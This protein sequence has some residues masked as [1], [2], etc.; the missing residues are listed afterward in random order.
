MIDR[1]GLAV[2]LGDWSARHRRTAVL[3]WLLFVVLATA[4]GSMA[5]SVRTDDVDNGVGESGRAV[6]IL[7][8]AGVTPAAAETVLIQ[9]ESLTSDDPAFRGAV[10]D[11]LSAV[12]ATGRVVRVHSP[13]ETGAVSGDRHSALVDFAVSG[14]PVAAAERVAPVL[15]AV[16]RT[17]AAHPDLRIEE[18]GAAGG[19]KA[20]KD[21]F[22][23]D[24]KQ[25]EWTAVPLALGILL[26]VFG[27]LVA[28]VLPVVLAITAFMGAAG[29]LAL[30]TRA[31]HTSD[32][33]ASVMLLVG[34]AVGVDYCLF[35]LRREREER[36]AGRDP[37]AALRIA[38]ATSG[39]SVLVSGL[40]VVA[41]MAG[42]FLTGIADFR[43]M[44][45]ATIMVVVVAVLGSVTVLPALLS[46]LGD[47]VE[48][49]RIPLLGRLRNRNAG[50]SRVWAAV[51]GRVLSRP[52]L[53]ALLATGALLALSVPMLGM[54]TAQLSAAQEL[55]GGN[56]VVQTGERIARAFPGNP[57]PATVV[58]EGV[59]VQGAAF[60]R[61]VADFE[62]RALATGRIHPPVTV[63]AYGP[64][65]VAV[66]SAAL[67]GTGNDPAS[68]AALRSLRDSVVPETLGR[69]P[70]AEVAV[71]GSTAASVDFNKQLTASA[72]PVFGFVLALAFVL[73][74]LSFRSVVI[75]GTAVLLN[76]LSVGAA[77]GALTLVFQHGVGA[78]LLGARATGAIA[79]WLP[80][81][82]F[83][84]LFGLSMDY[85]VF[86]VSRIKEGHDQGLGTREAV[87]HGIGSTAGVVTSAAVIMIGVFAV[88]GT[89]SVSSMKE[90]GVGLAVAVL[91]DA[92]VIRGIL[93]PAVMTL[94]GERNWYLPR[95]LS[96]LPDLSHGRP[97][98]GTEVPVTGPAA[99]PAEAVPQPSG[100]R[101][102]SG[103]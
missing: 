23:E 48:G 2:A 88:F 8:N 82:L 11:V 20:F 29:L 34:L 32:D 41:A 12:R 84:I 90:I 58:V 49:G 57:L 40:T 70:G 5:G 16:A 26:V 7:D 46:M 51:L 45:M 66:V 94:L 22:A 52:L 50:G 4:I 71:G 36:A 25:A 10:T 42:M 61:A 87:A 103:L 55:P 38:A 67:D 17:R 21:T 74:L 43:A 1:S 93:L 79:S 69:L 65:R 68:V 73:M 76:L 15:D 39:H 100:T 44:G 28:A 101:Q 31:V 33:A 35:Y 64:Q 24:F 98:T 97:P 78:S 3:G 60:D 89:L 59:D 92:T 85:H 83:V 77:Y 75:A 19:Q 14:D 95:M 63:S 53:S 27:A 9:S 30:S 91:L 86:V 18:F 96:W 54:H 102:R 72:L 80:L 99:R 62:Q 47:R 37:A 81:F 6:V 56:A 13:Y